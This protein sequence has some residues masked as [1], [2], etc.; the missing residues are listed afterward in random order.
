M[1]RITVISWM[2]TSF[3]GTNEDASAGDSVLGTESPSAYEI[4]RINL[5]IKK[6]IQYIHTQQSLI[7]SIYKNMHACIHTMYGWL[8]ANLV[9]W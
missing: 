6:F 9:C 8:Y 3:R 5:I 7:S 1:L 2:E 4:K